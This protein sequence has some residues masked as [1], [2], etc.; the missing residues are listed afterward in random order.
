L[1]KCQSPDFVTSLRDLQHKLFNAGGELAMPGHA[2][3]TADNVMAIE[4][5]IDALNDGLPP[6]KEFVLPGGSLAAAKAHVV[7]TVVRRAERYAFDAVG[8]M[9]AHAQL[10]KWLNRC[11]DYFFALSRIL[12]R[13]E[14]EEVLWNNPTK[15]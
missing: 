2:L 4:S 8:D 5:M 14:G 12:A 1:V 15:S 6:L 7:R 3:I 10:L 9:E 11:S 13:R